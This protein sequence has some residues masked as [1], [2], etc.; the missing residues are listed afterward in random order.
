MTKSGFKFSTSPWPARVGIA[1]AVI[2]VI[3]AGWTLFTV[4]SDRSMGTFVST[5][6]TLGDWTMNVDTCTS[7]KFP[8][9]KFYSSKDPRLAVWMIEDPLHGLVASVNSTTQRVAKN[10]E[11]S[12]CSVLTGHARESD[13]LY[14]PLK[15]SGEY[16]VDCKVD[17]SHLTGHIVFKHCI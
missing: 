13:P 17:Q 6:P 3:L 5:G 4:G 14:P 11:S 10:L 2:L 8:G 16:T 15:L 12:D 1:A 7:G 9:A